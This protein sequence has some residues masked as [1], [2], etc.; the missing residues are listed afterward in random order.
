MPRHPTRAPGRRREPHRR[1]RNRP[2]RHDAGQVGNRIE[3]EGIDGLVMSEAEHC[4][5]RDRVPSRR[6][7]A[8]HDFQRPARLEEQPPPT[9]RDAVLRRRAGLR[10]DARRKR[11]RGQQRDCLSSIHRSISFNQASAAA[12][13]RRS[14][15]G[16]RSPPPATSTALARSALSMNS[17]PSGPPVRLIVRAEKFTSAVA[18][19]NSRSRRANSVRGSAGV[20]FSTSRAV[21]GPLPALLRTLGRQL[22]SELVG[23]RGI[24]QVGEC[25]LD[26][27]HE[28]VAVLGRHL[29]G[30]QPHLLEAG[31]LL[32]DVLL[33]LGIDRERVLPLG[34]QPT[35]PVGCCSWP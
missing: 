13:P 4:P 23:V 35:V 18:V 10:A 14:L 8:Y 33:H 26:L 32:V 30:G 31:E 11:K 12:R 25:L 19:R 27:L 24:G 2:R 7:F 34:W 3:R 15:R 28:H 20:V 22:R 9:E 21:S 29:F 16:R 1:L 17:M 5:L 6:R